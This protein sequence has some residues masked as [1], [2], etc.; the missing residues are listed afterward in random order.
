M[1]IE[2]IVKYNAIERTFP[3]NMRLDLQDQ[4]L[5]SSKLFVSYKIKPS[6]RLIITAPPLKRSGNSILFHAFATNHTAYGTILDLE[7]IFTE[8]FL[9]TKIM[10]IINPIPIT[11]FEEPELLPRKLFSYISTR[12]VKIYSYAT[13]A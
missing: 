12:G 13:R 9:Q 7:P 5:Y 6:I 2:Q 4:L 10:P 8:W 11:Y 1:N 3:E